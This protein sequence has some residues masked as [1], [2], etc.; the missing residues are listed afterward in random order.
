MSWGDVYMASIAWCYPSVLRSLRGPGPR[1]CCWLEQLVIDPIL[2]GRPL[3]SMLNSHRYQYSITLCAE[4]SA[5]ALLINFWDQEEKYNP[6][7]WITL[8]IVLILCLNIFAVG[9]YGEAEFIF[10]SIKVSPN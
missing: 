8:I 6:A 9:I 7:I 2:M 10:A 3:D 1:F 4:I 5:A